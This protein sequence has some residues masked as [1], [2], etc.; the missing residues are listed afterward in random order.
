MASTCARGGSAWILGENLEG[1]V[2]HWNKL[3]C[4]AVKSPPLEVFKKYKDVI[5]RDMV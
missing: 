4:E 5:L 3:P 1:V 2:R